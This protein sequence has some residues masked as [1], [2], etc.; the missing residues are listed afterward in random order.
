MPAMKDNKGKEYGIWRS[1][2]A[3]TR[4]FMLW[5]ARTWANSVPTMTAP[6]IRKWMESWRRRVGDLGVF[7]RQCLL[8]ARREQ[9]DAVPVLKGQSFHL[10]A[11]EECGVVYPS[12][13]TP[14]ISA[15][16]AS[17]GIVWAIEHTDPVDVLHN[18][19]PGC[20]SGDRTVQLESGGI[21]GTTSE[22][23]ATS[24]LR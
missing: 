23:P 14:S 10:T 1:E 17:N 8:Q 2:R 3:K 5:I 13:T 22:A 18:R 12:G 20:K 15:D 6:F 7:Q 19:L 11:F 16:G 4:T 24:E 21:S 9:S